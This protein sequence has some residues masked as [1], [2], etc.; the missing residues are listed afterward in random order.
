M[1]EFNLTLQLLE[2]LLYLIVRY[3]F[4]PIITFLNVITSDFVKIYFS[5]FLIIK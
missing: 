2:N 3:H 1:I 5:V 4:K